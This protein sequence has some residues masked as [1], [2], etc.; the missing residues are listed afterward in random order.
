MFR[1]TGCGLVIVSM[2]FISCQKV[3]ESYYSYK[4]LEDVITV[5]QKIQYENFINIPYKELFEKIGFDKNKFMITTKSNGY[6]N[7]KNINEVSVFFDNLGKRDSHSENK[8]LQDNMEKF[9]LEKQRHINRYN[10]I[11]KTHPL[12]G[13]SIGMIII[14]FLI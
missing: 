8:Y 6:V 3:F 5:I 13:F 12:C 9:I 11:K 7:R 2:V 4:F 1:L 14:I 10:N